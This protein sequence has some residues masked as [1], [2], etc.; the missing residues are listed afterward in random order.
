MLISDPPCC[1]IPGARNYCN[2][3][4]CCSNCAQFG[5]NFFHQYRSKIFVFTSFLSFL[6]LILAAICLASLSYSEDTI[7]DIYWTKGKSSNYEI[8]IGLNKVVT[9]SGNYDW[10]NVNCNQ[11]YSATN[12][13]TSSS[14]SS[15]SDSLFFP[16]SVSHFNPAVGITPSTDDT[17][18]NSS[19]SSSSYAGYCHDCQDAVSGIIGTVILNFISLIPTISSNLKRSTIEGDLNCTKVF[20]IITGIISTISM[21]IALS[22]YSTLCYKNLPTKGPEGD[23]I[24]YSLGPAFICLLIP[25]IIKPIEV[26]INF[27]T[28]VPLKKEENSGQELQQEDANP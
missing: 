6:A 16:S 14:V 15:P 3:N 9:S 25:Q 24:T 19:S 17:D 28:P 12:F 20:T 26:I 23:T 27:L 13:T 1:A 4:C 8:F 18:D 10:K 22:E 11:Y 2:N 7:R 5:F 21:L